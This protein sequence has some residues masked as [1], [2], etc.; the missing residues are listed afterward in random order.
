[1]IEITR[2]EAVS[3]TDLLDAYLLDIIRSNPDIVN[4]EWLCN[5]MEIYK[6]CQVGLKEERN[7]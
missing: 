4:V 7:G 6:K 2:D 5:L 3:L 1:M